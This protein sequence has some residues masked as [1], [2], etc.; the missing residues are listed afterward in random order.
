MI[1]PEK[2]DA[3]LTALDSMVARIMAQSGLSEEAVVALVKDQYA[4]DEVAEAGTS[5]THIATIRGAYLAAAKQ[6]EDKLATNPEG[7]RSLLELAT[8]IAS[9]KSDITSL[10]DLVNSLGNVFN[11]VGT[12]VGGADAASAFDLDTLPAN[13]K[14]PGDYH[15]VATTGF[16]KSASTNGGV[17]FKVNATDGLVWNLNSGVDIIDNTT[18]VVSGTADEITV[19]GDSTNGFTIAIAEAFKT[20][21]NSLGSVLDDLNKFGILTPLSYDA[22]LPN[23]ALTTV[24]ALAIGTYHIRGTNSLGI[25]STQ[26]AMHGTMTVSAGRL[27]LG[28]PTRIINIAILTDGLLY[29]RQVLGDTPREGA[30]TNATVTP[31]NNSE[32]N[33][34]S[35]IEVLTTWADGAATNI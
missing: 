32:A 9:A 19:T 30:A 34:D 27:L 23:F 35:L 20:R 18:G 12:V 22:V 31:W 8:N 14:E 21:L 2:K 4:T 6:L 26:P 15:S 25:V 33:L 5:N 16:F 17:A 29:T 13:Q 28:E 24:N 1:N 10:S 7:Y 11:Y 3:L